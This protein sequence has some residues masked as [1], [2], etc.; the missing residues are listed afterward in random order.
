MDDH[1]DLMMSF[2]RF[3]GPEASVLS[4]CQP[5]VSV[6]SA[7]ALMAAQNDPMQPRAMILMA[8][9]I[10]TRINPTK[11]NE[12]AET[13]DLSWFENT[14]IS[15]VP[16]PHMGAMRKVYP[17]F[18]QLSGFMSLNLDRH[19]EAH[20]DLYNHLIEGDGD[21]AEQHR[22]FYDEYLA[23][24]DLPAE[25]FLQTI[26]KVFKEHSLPRGI[27]THRGTLV[28]PGKIKKTAL[29]TIEGANDDICGIGQTSAAL[30][31]CTNLPD[32]KKLNYIQQNVGH[33]GVFNGKR[34]RTEIKPRM[35]EFIRTV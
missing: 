20:L 7:V 33:Y 16:F 8:G 32:D 34:W 28:E 13:K 6:L 31:L 4:V 11:V 30:D 1:I 10:D 26:E 2:M 12:H 19:V 25:L 9:P 22:L 15:H 24:M 18:V 35:A 5:A 29:M 23:V 3:L 17:G 27:L 14:V 21:S